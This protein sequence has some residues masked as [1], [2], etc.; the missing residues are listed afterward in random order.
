MLSRPKFYRRF[1]VYS[2]SEPAAN[3]L[4]GPCGRIGKETGEGWDAASEI[5][6]GTNSAQKS[7]I[8]YGYVWIC[9]WISVGLR[10]AIS[11]SKIKLE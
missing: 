9:M 2:P 8:A 4:P 5:A 1:A 11:R 3:R 6:R 10:S 7:V